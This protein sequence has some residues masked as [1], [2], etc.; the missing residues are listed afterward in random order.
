MNDQQPAGMNLGFA[1]E[2]LKQGSR[3]TRTAWNGNGMSLAIP[4]ED[5]PEDWQG[6]AQLIALYTPS[7]FSPWN[8]AQ[9]DLLAEDWQ[10]VA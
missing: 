2:A 9:V 1:I 8:P 10:V 3:V 4:D 7:G 6:N 5:L